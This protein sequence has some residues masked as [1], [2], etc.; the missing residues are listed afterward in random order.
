MRIGDVA[1]V[2]VEVTTIFLFTTVTAVTTHLTP[3]TK[4]G[5]AVYSSVYYIE[6]C[7]KTWV[8]LPVGLATVA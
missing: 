5:V 2:L 3:Y 1:Y 8:S 7:F 4:G 6:L